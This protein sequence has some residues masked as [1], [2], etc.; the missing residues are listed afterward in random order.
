MGNLLIDDEKKLAFRNIK[1]SSTNKKIIEEFIREPKK[2]IVYTSFNGDYINYIYNICNYEIRR[3]NIPLNPELGL[4][5]YISTISLGGVKQ[6][7]ME[8]CLTLEM[9]SN[10][11][12]VYR[13]ESN[14]FAEG[15]KAEII[16]WYKIKN[17]DIDIIGNLNNPTKLFLESNWDKA[18][19]DNY[20]TKLS[21]N[22]KSELYNN[23]LSKYTSEKHQTAYIIANFKNYKH[24]DWSRCFCYKNNICPISP[25]NIL[26]YFL[27]SDKLENYKKSRL[28]LLRRSD[29][30][31]LFIDKKNFN[32]EINDLDEYSLMELYYLLNYDINKKIIVV[33]WDEAEV[34]KYVM[35]KNWSLTKKEQF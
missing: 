4:G 21:V 15:I 9:L 11:M 1:I 25:Q 20:I 34:P 8:D 5:Y 22:E 17:V 19:L 30:V 26:P 2:N 27:Y 23:L 3:G 35:R 18:N 16:L 32:N 33:G 14:D 31:Y 29:M 13:D 10:K 24:I 12:S 6:R 7:V 28:E